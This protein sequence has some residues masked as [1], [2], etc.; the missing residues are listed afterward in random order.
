MFQ[1]PL[2]FGNCIEDIIKSC[3]LS[4]KIFFFTERFASGQILCALALY[5]QNQSNKRSLPCILVN[6]TICLRQSCT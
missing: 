5:P 3:C 2:G 4:V 1:V 6:I